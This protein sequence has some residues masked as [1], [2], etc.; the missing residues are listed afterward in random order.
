M[1][2]PIESSAQRAA[3]LAQHLLNFSNDSER[4]SGIVDLTSSL[5]TFLFLI[6]ESFVIS[7]LK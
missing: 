5:K 1:Q 7:K 3:K 6:K 2:K 4:V